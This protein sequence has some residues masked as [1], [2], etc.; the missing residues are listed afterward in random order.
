MKCITNFFNKENFSVPFHL[1]DRSP[2]PFLT[3][4]LVLQLPLLIYISPNK[5][6][7]FFYF[8]FTLLCIIKY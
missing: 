7:I 8:F 2:W 3:G 6:F 1:V 4:F 5:V